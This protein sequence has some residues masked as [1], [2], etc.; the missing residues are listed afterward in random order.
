[1]REKVLEIIDSSFGVGINAISSAIMGTIL[2]L[3]IGIVLVIIC[4]K[5]NLFKRR[6]KLWNIITKIYYVYI[7][8]VIAIFG[9]IYGGIYGLNKAVNRTIEKQSTKLMAVI[10][11]EMPDF[12]KHLKEIINSTNLAE[13]STEDA[14]ERYF[15]NKNEEEEK[16]MFDQVYDKAANWVFEGTLKGLIS[17]YSEELGIDGSTAAGTVK[18]LRSVDFDNL[19]KSAA[20]IVSKFITK[21]SNSFFRGWYFT[22]LFNLL[23][24]LSIPIVETSLYFIIVKPNKPKKEEI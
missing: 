24:F 12:Q 17:H 9:A 20:S 11:P 10:I 1:M 19:D 21:Q 15:N 7:P 3:I 8:I 14:I 2:F 23:L 13:F 4:S 5:K 22:Q 6:N 18:I 16:G